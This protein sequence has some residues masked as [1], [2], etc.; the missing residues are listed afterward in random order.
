MSL[1]WVDVDT[2]RLLSA[3]EL[4]LRYYSL[5]QALSAKNVS[6][7]MLPYFTLMMMLK[8]IAAGRV[9][10]EQTCST[11]NKGA[12]AGAETQAIVKNGK[13]KPG[14]KGGRDCFEHSEATWRL[15]PSLFSEA[16]KTSTIPGLQC[17]KV[18]RLQRALCER[19]FANLQ[20][21]QPGHS[22]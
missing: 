16:Q 4:Y 12:P 3:S 21:L 20:S 22:L 8:M 10:N 19:S 5:F 11:K 2:E 13:G 6:A 14:T 17:T 1:K 9:R 15:L 18:E 7:I